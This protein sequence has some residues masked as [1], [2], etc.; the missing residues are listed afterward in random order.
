MWVRRVRQQCGVHAKQKKQQGKKECYSCVAGVGAQCDCAGSSNMDMWVHGARPQMQYVN[1]KI[2]TQLGSST[3]A[4][5]CGLESM[6]WNATHTRV[7]N[8]ES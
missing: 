8:S 5:C 2:E 4:A 3:A 6:L 7:F 1:A